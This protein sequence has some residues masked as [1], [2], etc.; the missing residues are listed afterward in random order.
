MTSTVLVDVEANLFKTGSTKSRWRSLHL[1]IVLSTTSLAA[2]IIF[3]LMVQENR[4]GGLGSDI[5][6]ID[7]ECIGVTGLDGEMFHFAPDDEDLVAIQ[8]WIADENRSVRDSDDY[9]RIAVLMPMTSEPYSPLSR[10]KIL[11]SLRGAYIAQH[12]ANNDETADHTPEVELLLANEGSFQ[13][14]WK[15]AVEQLIDLADDE[16]P[17]VAVVGLGVSIPETR[18]AAQMLAEHDLATIGAALTA[19]TIDDLDDLE[20]AGTFVRV[21]P[22]NNDYVRALEQYL[23]SRRTGS[24]KG[25]IVY[26]D[27]HIED[28]VDLYTDTLKS[29]YEDTLDEFLIEP[30]RS[31]RFVRPTSASER[32]PDYFTDIVQNI[33][34][35]ESE[36]IFY[37]GRENELRDNLLPEL[38]DHDCAGR[39][40][41]LLI[42]TG[43][44]GLASI[45]QDV[46]VLDDLKDNKIR[47]IYASSYDPF[48]WLDETG[49]PPEHHQDFRDEFKDAFGL[50][51][52]D[53]VSTELADG[54]AMMHHDAVLVAVEAIDSTQD[55]TPR[56]VSGA[57]WNLSYTNAVPGASGTLSFN[58]DEAHGGWPICKP[59][60][61]V[62]IPAYSPNTIPGAYYTGDDPNNI[63]E[64]YYTGDDPKVCQ[65]SS[66]D[67]TL[68]SD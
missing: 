60:P 17:L 55:P 66:H 35:A 23:V 31:Q 36:M 37:A 21:S 7:S 67:T 58:Q 47:I 27:T 54:Y 50:L 41:E 10:T 29:N 8:E 14:H 33:C 30:L 59:V 46:D 16:H 68:S 64:I 1:L 52:S 4:C 6:R 42:L 51:D 25:I 44:T 2:G 34:Q 38:V 43:V 32:V 53:Q 63:P 62:A 22:S 12:R 18:K 39:P 5:L 65:S 13:T 45:W 26:D 15:P 9:V 49:S 28:G 40:G 56:D 57:L 19:D 48:H 20:G 3:A 61:I 11:N 24:H